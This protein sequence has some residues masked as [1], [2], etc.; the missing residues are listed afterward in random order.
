M[1][2]GLWETQPASIFLH[3]GLGGRALETAE[4]LFH[5]RIRLQRETMRN[6]DRPAGLLSAVKK[7]LNPPSRDCIPGKP[8][9][10]IKNAG[11]ADGKS[12]CRP[13]EGYVIIPANPRFP[14]NPHP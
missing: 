13:A 11:S 12:H 2:A 7:R 5:E 1:E 10:L 14:E 4:H 3:A 6:P 8:G 9:G